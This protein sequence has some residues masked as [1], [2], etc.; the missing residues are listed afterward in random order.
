MKTPYR[1]GAWCRSTLT[2][3]NHHL[4]WKEGGPGSF[5]LSFYLY[6]YRRERLV[7]SK[8]W[9]TSWE[10]LEM[11]HAFG[12]G[13]PYLWHLKFKTSWECMEMHHALG[14][15]LPYLWHLNYKTSWEFMEMHHALEVGLPYLWHLNFKTSWECMEI[16][17]ELGDGASISLGSPLNN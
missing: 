1:H 12:L 3:D 11:H 9:T 8:I 15:G 13:V 10:C 7:T 14:V 17:H 6:I 5:F 2:V 16:H 4:L